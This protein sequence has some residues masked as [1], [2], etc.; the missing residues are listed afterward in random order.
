MRRIISIPPLACL[1][2]LA[3]ILQL[4]ADDSIPAPAVFFLHQKMTVP[5]IAALVDSALGDTARVLPGAVISSGGDGGNLSISG[6]K[7][8]G[9][10]IGELGEVSL[11]QGLEAQ[12]EGEVRSGTTLRAA[13]SDQGS[14]IDGSTREISDFDLMQVELTNDKFTITAGDQFAEWADGGILSGQKKI[15]GISAEVRP[16]RAAAGAFMSFSGGSHTV[17]TVRGREGVQGPYYL[18]GRGEAGIIT[19]VSGTVKV[20]VNGDDLVEGVDADFAVDYDIGAVTFNPRV[21]IGKDDFIRVEYEYKSFDYRRT[22]AGGGA[23][24][25]TRD[26]VLTV[27]GILWSESDDK[28][29]P[30]EMQLSSR[31]KDILKNSGNNPAYAASTARPVH[32]LDVARTSVF[33][34]LY[35]KAYDTAAGDTVLIYTPY[36]PMRPDDIRDFYTASFTSIQ[37]GTAGADYVI[38]TAVDRGQFVYK[39]AGAGR[40]D[41]TSLAPIAAP[42]RETAGEIQARLKSPYVNA[43]LNIAGKESDRNL[44]SSIDDGTDM[45]SAI[46]FKLNAGEK[47]FDRRSL[48]GDV[49]YRFRSRKF[50]DEIFS[51]DERREWWG[52]NDVADGSRGHQFQSW[53]ST[54]GGAVVRGAVISVGAG[55]AFVDSLAETEKITTDAQLRFAGDKYGVDL[56]AAVFRHHQ[57]II[58]ISHRRHGKFF[59]KPSPRWEASLDYRDEWRADTSG[60]GG[61]HFS[62]T[63]EAA[64]IPANLRQSLNVVRYRRGES[65]PGSTD[66][67]YTLT[68]N[69]S[70]SLSPLDKWRLTGDSRW[71]HT[72]IDGQNRTSTFL[73]SAVSEI[74]PTAA[75][76]SSRQE[77]RVNRE[78][79]SRFE[80]KMYYIGQGLGTH[81]FDSTMGEFRPSPHGDHIVQEVEIYDNTSSSTV[82]K[83]TLSGD[84]YF[85]PAKKVS[86][87]LNDLAWSGVLLLEEHVDSRNGAVTTYIPGLL[88]LFPYEGKDTSLSPYPNYAD[89]SYRQDIDYQIQGSPYRSRLYFLPGMRIIRGYKEPTFETGLL[90]ERKK[91]GLLLSVEPRYFAVRREN[92]PGAGSMH[93]AIDMSDA[94]AELVQRLGSGERFEYYLRER[95][96]LITD[97]APNRAG[98]NPAPSDSGI[99]IQIRPGV[100][101]RPARGGLAE[102]SYT[103]SYVPWPGPALDYRMAGSQR[104]G[105]AHIITL[106]GDINAGKYFNLSCLYRGELARRVGEKEYSPM[107]HLFSMHVKAFL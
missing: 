49:D 104:P 30:I 58:D 100:I 65:F 80:Q 44:F 15:V 12:I 98:V 92:L 33:H 90:V 35:K 76:F 46:M 83:T 88:S 39:Y 72:Q 11:E 26:S 22:F 43:S 69:Q 107:M 24:Y 5:S 99:Y 42:V 1:L 41:F 75:G 34:P 91:G 55:Q 62:G 54:V 94:G 16:G 31:E 13:L 82:R 93:T 47:R 79:A 23:A 67:G 25:Y 14:S 38:D 71:R 106:H 32:P 4:R 45:S 8:F 59:A 66:T 36:D 40:G 53:E 103:F 97:N 18:T 85:K 29:N 7:S 63:A 101:H 74:E 77:Y 64:Y 10:S 21:L 70:A 61:G 37:P 89:L 68:W 52:S 20:R 48:W 73:M 6:Y 3:A 105:T 50:S 95:A 86:G 56:G 84:W 51:A 2:I 9:V 102:L 81:A 28:N 60:L 78:T 17:Q 27:R 19:P 57:S 96:G 87:I